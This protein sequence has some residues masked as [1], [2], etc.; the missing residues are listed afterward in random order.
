MGPTAKVV[1]R[2]LAS[3]IASKHNQPYRQTINW[4]HCRLSFSLLQ[5]CTMCLRGSCSSVNHPSHPQI[6]EATIDHA[7]CDS[8]VNFYVSSIFFKCIYFCSLG[9]VLNCLSYSFYCINQFPIPFHEVYYPCMSYHVCYKKHLH[10]CTCF[11]SL[12]G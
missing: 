2:K 1:Y 6:L 5:S 4:L 7:L 9:L 11:I 10:T 12:R 3:M 8:R